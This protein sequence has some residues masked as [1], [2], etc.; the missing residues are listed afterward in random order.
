MEISKHDWTLSGKASSLHFFLKI[1]YLVPKVSN[2]SIFQ[3]RCFMKIIWHRI[4]KQTLLFQTCLPTLQNGVKNRDKAYWHLVV[5]CNRCFRLISGQTFMYHVFSILWLIYLSSLELFCLII[6]VKARYNFRLKLLPTIADHQN[7][8]T[9]HKSSSFW[10]LN[11]SSVTL[12]ER[13][14]FP[15]QA[16]NYPTYCRNTK[17]KLLWKFPT[18][19]DWRLRASVYEP[20]AILSVFQPCEL[21]RKTATTNKQKKKTFRGMPSGWFYS[22]PRWSGQEWLP[23]FNSRLGQHIVLFVWGVSR[24]LRVRVSMRGGGGG[25]NFE[26][27]RLHFTDFDGWRLRD[28]SSTS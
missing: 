20:L 27:W 9:C 23:R 28:I 18:V 4:S 8:K 1:V 14:V 12:I 26:A 15:Y 10:F 19:T 24:K 6:G 21:C 2:S 3:K 17:P 5:I 13:V 16:E 22:P 11:H 7:I 25:G